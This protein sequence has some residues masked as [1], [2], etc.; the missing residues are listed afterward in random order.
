MFSHLVYLNY[1]TTYKI[2]EKF[3]I[4]LDAANIAKT[5]ELKIT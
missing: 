3:Y 1:T 2:Q 4:Q 5:P